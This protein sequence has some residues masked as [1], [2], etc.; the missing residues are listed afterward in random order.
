MSWLWGAILFWLA[1]WGA[2]A[3]LARQPF[4]KGRAVRRSFLGG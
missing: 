1:A 2:N 3:W 4:A